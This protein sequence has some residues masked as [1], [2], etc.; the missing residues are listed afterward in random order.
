MAT[1]AQTLSTTSAFSVPQVHPKSRKMPSNIFRIL[2]FPDSR[3]KRHHTMCCSKLSSWE[4]SPVKYAPK[5]NT[6]DNLLTKTTSIFETLNA[7][8]SKA[9]EVTIDKTKELTEIKHQSSTQFQFLK[10]PLWILGPILLVATGMGPTLWL[11]ISSI[12]I[13]PNI[14][15]LLSLIGLDC[16]FNLGATLFLLMADA[17]AGPKDSTQGSDSNAPSVY[18]FWNMVAIIT[19]FIVPLAIIF[20]SEQGFLQPQL[21]F[22]SSAILLGPYFL[23]LSV[24]FLTE[25]LT[26]HWKSPVWLV[27]PVVYEA[28]R[29]L[30]LMRGL[31]LGAELSAPTWTL[32][33]IRCL[34]SWWVLILGIQLMRVAWFAGY[35]AQADKNQARS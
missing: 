29:I 6:S 8:N 14:A 11:P 2:P 12:F 24:Q 25:M 35:K 26:W 23:L 28:Y 31:K 5:E 22:I 19:G 13:G 17:C 9:E 15:S 34:V 27:T 1:L 3:K 32:H 20:G 21:T 10:W 4:P 30:Q 7:D 18:R 33:T 16:I